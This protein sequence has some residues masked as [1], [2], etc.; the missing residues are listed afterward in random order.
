MSTD[1]FWDTK[2]NAVKPMSCWTCSE[3]WS[4]ESLTLCIGTIMLASM[5]LLLAQTPT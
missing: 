3:D 2:M 1:G 4:I 5:G